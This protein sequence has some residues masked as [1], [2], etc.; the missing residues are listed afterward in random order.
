MKKV[1]VG[2]VL[3]W[4]ALPNGAVLA[5]GAAGCPPCPECPACDE[6]EKKDGWDI[7]A[8]LGFNL[9]RG[10]S[11]TLLLTGN[12]TAQR[13]KD[14]N[15][16]RFEIDGAHGE[17]KDRD[18][19]VTG[20]TTQKEI[21]ADAEYKRL[22]TER[23][24]VGATAAAIYDDIADVDYR[25]IVGLPVGYFLIKEEDMRLNAE[26]GPA[27]VFE[28]VAGVTNDY[29]SPRV[30]ERFEWDI[31]ETSKFYQ[32]VEVLFSVDDSD[33]TLVNSEA[34]IEAA[35]NSKLSLVLSVKDEYD[36]LPAEGRER[37]D[38]TVNTALKIAL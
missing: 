37:N 26:V 25:Y 20:N 24:Y 9:T 14:S 17:D 30:A 6:E 27:Y 35:I 1:C 21:R 3:L 8:A 33:D 23:F 13:E 4:C 31:S 10:N 38:L 2:V 18:D 36:N 12:V 34:G 29:F 22:L 7:S 19:P 15:I 5:E 16:L 28:K 11:D 32:S